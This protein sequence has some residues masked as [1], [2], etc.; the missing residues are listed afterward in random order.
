MACQDLSTLGSNDSG[1]GSGIV[2][3]LDKSRQQDHARNAAR[4]RQHQ[5][6]AELS[7]LDADEYQKDI[8]EHTLRMDVSKPAYLALH[9]PFY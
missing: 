4:Q 6:A 7:R 8:L 9:T 1:Y 3:V 5:L 2:E